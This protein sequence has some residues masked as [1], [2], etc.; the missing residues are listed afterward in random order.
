MELAELRED[1]SDKDKLNNILKDQLIIANATLDEM[2][3]LKD[4]IGNS[5][6][7]VIKE[8][9]NLRVKLSQ[10]EHSTYSNGDVANSCA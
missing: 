5:V 2:V 6:Q 9:E 7:N 1:L 10:L 3:A 4:V 8:N